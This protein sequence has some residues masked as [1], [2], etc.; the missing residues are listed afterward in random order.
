MT[1]VTQPREVG[2]GPGAEVENLLPGEGGEK[3]RDLREAG[4]GGFVE[5]R[6]AD[7]GVPLEQRVP[8]RSAAR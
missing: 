7:E 5:E 6:R 3:G 1:S 2:P 4:Q 8:R